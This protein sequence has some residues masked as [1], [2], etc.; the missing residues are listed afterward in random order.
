MFAAIIS[1]EKLKL[2]IRAPRTN[3]IIKLVR[4]A[5]AN[6]PYWTVSANLVY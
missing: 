2:I 4:Y 6:P 3:L 5:L 1:D